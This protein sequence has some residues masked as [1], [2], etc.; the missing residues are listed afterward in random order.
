MACLEEET[1]VDRSWYPTGQPFHRFG[2]PGWIP[3]AAS[4]SHV[5]KGTAVNTRYIRI[6][7]RYQKNGPTKT[8]FLPLSL[9]SLLYIFPSYTTSDPGWS[10]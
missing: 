9:P 1:S 3:H 7:A 5:G 6:I 10:L 8:K 2:A 4:D